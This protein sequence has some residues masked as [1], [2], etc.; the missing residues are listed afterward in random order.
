[1]AQLEDQGDTLY[2]LLALADG[3][4]A[5]S[6]GRCARYES[7]MRTIHRSRCRLPQDDQTVAERVHALLA[8][9]DAATARVVQATIAPE[10]ASSGEGETASSR[11]TEQE[12]ASQPSERQ[13]RER[14]YF[15][16]KQEGCPDGRAQEF[17]E[18]ARQMH[19][20]ER[21]LVACQ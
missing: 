4:I 11:E 15:L 6:V 20:G 19:Q 2:R 14:A 3:D 17:W 5:V 10:H 16:W 1:M 18:R 21:A 8:T 12:S 9:A 13:L 7:E